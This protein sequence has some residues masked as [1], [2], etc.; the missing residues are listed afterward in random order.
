V[1][2]AGTWLQA[3]AGLEHTYEFT[4]PG[5]RLLSI[6]TPSRDLGRY[7]RGVATSTSP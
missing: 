7:L 4:A 2:E 1:A 5:A 6:H 3:P